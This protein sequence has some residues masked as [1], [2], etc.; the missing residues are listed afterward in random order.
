[1][2]KANR[3]L[4]APRQFKEMPHRGARNR[5]WIL[6]RNLPQRRRPRIFKSSNAPHTRNATAGR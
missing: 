4:E 2:S 3:D 5:D 6:Y 1:M